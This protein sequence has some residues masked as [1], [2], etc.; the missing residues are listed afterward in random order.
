VADL[1][2]YLRD[3]L[4]ACQCAYRWEFLGHQTLEWRERVEGCPMHQVEESTDEL[5][6]RRMEFTQRFEQASAEQAELSRGFYRPRQWW[7]WR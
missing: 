2:D 1:V 4:L 3:K 5:N 7:P 6:R